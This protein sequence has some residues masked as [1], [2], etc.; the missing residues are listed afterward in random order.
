MIKKIYRAWEVDRLFGWSASTRKRKIRAGEFPPPISLG[1]QMVG[2]PE[3]HIEPYRDALIEG[4][5]TEAA[6]AP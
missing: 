3:E 5:K 1:P 6:E 4:K 2:W